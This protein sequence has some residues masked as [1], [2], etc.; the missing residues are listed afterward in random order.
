VWLKATSEAHAHELP[1]TNIVS[2][3]CGQFTPELIAIKRDWNAWLSREAGDALSD[4]SGYKMLEWAAHSLIGMQ[5]ASR[6]CIDE[7]RKAGCSDLSLSALHRYL[8]ALKGYIDS[9]MAQQRSTRVPPLSPSQISEMLNLLTDAIAALE[10]LEIGDVLL[11]NDLNS[12]NVLIHGK[13][14]IFIDWAEAGIGNPWLGLHHIL[15]LAMERPQL[16][17]KTQHLYEVYAEH[18][19]N[20]LSAKHIS[21]AY[22]LSGP[23]AIVCYLCGRDSS[24]TSAHRDIESVQSYA[25]SLAR[26]LNRMVHTTEFRKAL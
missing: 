3:R 6:S 18:W 8:P 12:G 23:L 15:A 19:R 17:N 11:H 14:A 4:R 16:G 2:R 20:R 10:K 25:R 26:H 13:K 24:F 22:L 1:I 5:L 21:K 7:L 9:A